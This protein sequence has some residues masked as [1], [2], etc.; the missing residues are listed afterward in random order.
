M[1]M[2]LRLNHYLDLSSCN[3][4]KIFAHPSWIRE[5]DVELMFAVGS[6]RLHEHVRGQI[7]LHVFF[8]IKNH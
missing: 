8:N 6:I 7:I 2:K 4:C 3:L 1:D 5:E